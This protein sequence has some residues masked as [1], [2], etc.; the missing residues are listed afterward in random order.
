MES[1]RQIDEI[2]FLYPRELGPNCVLYDLS[3][4]SAIDA[5]SGLFSI[6]V[7]FISAILPYGCVV[8]VHP[9]KDAVF[10]WIVGQIVR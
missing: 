10:Y 6:N 4:T 1:T 9:N 3:G 8:T 7:C 2:A 5:H